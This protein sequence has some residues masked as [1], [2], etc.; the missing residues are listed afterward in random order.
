MNRKPSTLNLHPTPQT[1][2][3]EEEEEEEWGGQGERRRR[4]EEEVEEGGEEE[5]TAVQ[6]KVVRGGHFYL[7]R[8]ALKSFLDVNSRTNP[9]TYPLL[10]LT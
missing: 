6:A 8:S 3:Q 7:T 2:H 10:L 4:E 1:L 9:S 5:D